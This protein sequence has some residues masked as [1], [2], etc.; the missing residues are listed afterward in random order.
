MNLASV[1][2]PMAFTPYKESNGRID[3][4]SLGGASTLQTQE[5]SRQ[6][7]G[8][9][10]NTQ[11]SESV[12]EILGKD[13]FLQL[14][15]TQLRYQDPLSPIDDQ[16]F[17]AQMA[18]FSALE[19]MQNLTTEM[20]R[21]ADLQWLSTRMAQATAL[22]GKTVEVQL[23]SGTIRGKVDAVVLENG[24]PRLAIGDYVFDLNDVSAITA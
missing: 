10:Q 13:T 21:F 15:T 16:D 6:Q 11:L 20:R 12:Q 24:L 7:A 8:T 1:L 2:L 14:L 3:P 9:T 19:Q 4:L 22:L 23:D 5:A 18:Q 17:I